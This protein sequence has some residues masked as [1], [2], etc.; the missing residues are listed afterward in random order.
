VQGRR[1][2]TLGSLSAAFTVLLGAAQGGADA[3]ARSLA[4]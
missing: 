4:A 1:A 2:N 3:E